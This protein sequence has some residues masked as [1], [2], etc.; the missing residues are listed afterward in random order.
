MKAL[1]TSFGAIIAIVFVI[2]ANAS[3]YT[4]D[5]R[6]QV[7]V[8]Q[9]GKPVGEPIIEPGLHFKLP[10]IQTVNT[11]PRLVLEWDGPAVEMQTKEKLNIQVDNFARWRIIE[12]LTFLK[13]M[14]DERTAQS[15][16][17]DILGSETRNVVARYNFI[18]MV[19]T[20]K[21][22]KVEHDPNVVASLADARLGIMQEIVAGRQK[23]EEEILAN[24]KPKV[25]GFGIE[26]LDLRMKRV[27]YNAEVSESIHT[28]MISERKQIA[29]RFRSEGAGEAA[30]I[31]GSRERDLKEIESVAYK[32]VQDIEGAA[33]AKALEI[34]ARAYNSTP[35][36][37]QLFEFTKAMDTLKKSI[38][39]DTTLILTS[40]GD[41]LRYLKGADIKGG[42]PAEIEGLK[43]I[44]G[45][46]SLL[47]VPTIK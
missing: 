14:R 12:P 28:R 31:E 30:K 38:T 34:Y 33:D 40:D 39:A 45:L 32:K 1:L 19:R 26:L 17:D 16:L 9:F 43:G 41:L 44:P 8:T 24:A 10:F 6:D 13:Q 4:V 42:G 5:Q 25:L 46:P 23:L 2:V 18:E 7:I 15:R 36:A 27:N 37:V 20:T 29:E 21:G 11:F 3:I 47:D 22:R 35:E